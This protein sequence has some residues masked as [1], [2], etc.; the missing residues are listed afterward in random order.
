MQEKLI[1]N[2]IE[3]C[4]DRKLSCKILMFMDGIFAVFFIDSFYSFLQCI[5]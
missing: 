1:M 3:I 5:L 4:P 2:E